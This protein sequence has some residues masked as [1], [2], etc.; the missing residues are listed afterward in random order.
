MLGVLLIVGIILDDG[1]RMRGAK[2]ARAGCWM[3]DDGAGINLIL[4]SKGF[5]CIYCILA[6][7]MEMLRQL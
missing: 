5:V 7:A 3:L 2:E 6:G 4:R 1:Y